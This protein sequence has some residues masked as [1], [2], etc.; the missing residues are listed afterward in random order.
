MGITS[1]LIAEAQRHLG[2]TEATGRNDGEPIETWQR[3][4]AAAVGKP[5][6]FYIGAPWCAIFQLHV[7]QAVNPPGFKTAYCHPYTGFMC[8]A[9]RADDILRMDPVP[10]AIMVKC[11][12]HTGLVT[13]VRGALIDTIEGNQANAVRTVVRAA[14]DW[15]YIVGPWVDD[16]EPQPQLVYGFDDLDVKPATYGPWMTADGRDKMMRLFVSERGLSGLWGP[17]PVLLDKDAPA[18]AFRVGAEGTYGANWRFGPWASKADRDMAMSKR[19]ANTGHA[20]RP[21]NRRA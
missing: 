7:H 14:R 5:P 13:G 12:V 9:A 19:A 17:V 1:Q 4:A 2:V 18:H 21:W 3:E 10:G 6:T 15:L 16:V 11:G 8:A 20:M